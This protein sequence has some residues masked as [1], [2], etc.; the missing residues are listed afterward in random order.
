ME[1][2]S[3]AQKEWYS[4]YYA[5]LGGNRNSLHKNPG[6]LFQLLALEKAF[7][8]ALRAVKRNPSEM[9]VLN[10]GCGTGADLFYLLRIGCRPG[11]I[12]AVDVQKERLDSARSIYSTVNF[13]C[14]DAS[15]MTFPDATF[16]LLFESTMFSTLPDEI[17]SSEIAAEMV[18]VCKPGGYLLLLDWRIQ[19]PYDTSYRALTKRRLSKLFEL[20]SKTEIVGVYP[21]ALVPPVGRFLSAYLPG[22]YFLVAS[23]MPFLVGQ[24]GY[25]LRK[26]VGK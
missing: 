26:K 6:V 13:V 1:N 24:V 16:D 9:S 18:R 5:K 15:K 7:V 4:R 3:P 14:C 2:D 11:N 10:V 17:V 20:D 8:S 23:L 22:L 12:T 25:L 19:K 21:G